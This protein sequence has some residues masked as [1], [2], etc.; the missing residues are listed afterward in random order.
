MTKAPAEIHAKFAPTVAVYAISSANLGVIGRIA[1]KRNANNGRTRAL[2]QLFGAPE[3]EGAAGAA[4]STYAYH[5]AVRDAARAA[6]QGADPGARAILTAI[7][8]NAERG[9][10]RPLAG[11]IDIRILL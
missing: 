4:S 3:W 11:E 5:D 8:D 1:T 6:A 10:I 7:A 9:V 2:V